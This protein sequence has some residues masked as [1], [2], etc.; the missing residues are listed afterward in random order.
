M[1]IKNPKKNQL[2]YSCNLCDFKSS[3]KKDFNRHLL[4]AKHEILQN[5]TK[6]PQKTPY[7]EYTCNCGKQYRHHS[8]LWTHKKTCKNQEASILDDTIYDLEDI[9]LDTDIH[10]KNNSIC[11]IDDNSI[12]TELKDIIIKQ[13][14][15]IEKQQE[16]IGSII[17]LI[18]NKTIN[19]TQNNKFSIK[20]F[21]D[22]KCKDAINMTD[23][24]NS[25]K[26]SLEQLEYTTEH[27]LTDGL[28]KTI[29]DNMNRLSIYER[30][31][32]CTDVKRET[33]YI[34]DDD[35]WSKDNSRERMKLAIKGATN[36]NYRALKDWQGVHP[37]FRKDER[38]TEYFTDM[39]VKLG[40]SLHGIDDKVL[41]NICR[42]TYLRM[43][44]IDID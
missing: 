15:Q 41:R 35:K 39:I 25:I 6:K 13:Q 32:H 23:F 20:M 37:D 1:S 9:D 18:G 28:T 8:S 3:N 42:S 10:H 34:K 2:K 36:A 31:L 14:A 24:V 12:I 44:D 16:Q 43:S 22:E 11:N 27:G 26:V 29:M 33:L 38:L 21:L 7:G 19:N 40:K 30:P 4:T 17:P 5:T